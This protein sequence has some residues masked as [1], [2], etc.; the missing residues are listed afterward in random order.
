M[1]VCAA[2]GMLTKPLYSIKKAQASGP[3]LLA[4]RYLCHGSPRISCSDG[5][6]S[7]LKVAPDEI[8]AVVAHYADSGE[9][10]KIFGT[11]FRIAGEK[12]V[13]LKADDRSLYG[14][15][16]RTH[17]TW[18]KM[19][20]GKDKSVLIRFRIGQG[21]IVYMSNETSITHRPLR[22]ECPAWFRGKHGGA[23]RRLSHWRWLLNGSWEK[24][25]A[26]DS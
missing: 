21:R 6:R 22:G 7:C 15:K 9:T 2:P 24:K 23:A 19:R 13:T 20:R 5:S 10:K 8:K 17:S 3:V 14:K 25:N 18:W 1:K 26:W 11:G 16:V 12:Y 4:S